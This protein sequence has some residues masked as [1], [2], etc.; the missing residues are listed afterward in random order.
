[1]KEKGKPHYVVQVNLVLTIKKPP[2]REVVRISLLTS[3]L[4]SEGVLDTQFTT[5]AKILGIEITISGG[6]CLL[7]TSPSPRDKRQSRMPSSA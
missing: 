5:D 4:E 6:G 2:V 3:G 1:M 7:Y